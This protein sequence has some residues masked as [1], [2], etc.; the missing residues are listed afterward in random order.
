MPEQPNYG[1]IVKC[2]GKTCGQDII[3]V[4]YYSKKKG[5]FKKTCVNSKPVIVLLPI[6]DKNADPRFSGPLGPIKWVMRQAFIPHH[7]T[8]VDV[9]EFRKDRGRR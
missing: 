1:S 7:A 9:E 4:K 6:F 5:G 8:C 2:R 3:F